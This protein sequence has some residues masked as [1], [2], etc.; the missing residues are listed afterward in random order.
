MWKGVLNVFVMHV[1]HQQTANTIFLGKLDLK[2]KQEVL[3]SGEG[4]SVLREETAV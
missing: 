2:V 1:V 4:I 3:I